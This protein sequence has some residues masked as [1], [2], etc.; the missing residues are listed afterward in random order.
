MKYSFLCFTCYKISPYLSST[1]TV[2]LND[3]SRI[4]FETKGGRFAII[5]SASSCVQD[6][7]EEI[8]ANLHLFM[9]KLIRE[10]SFKTTMNAFLRY[11][12]IL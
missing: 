6:E 7:A 1:F 4:N 12:E 3:I 8:I 5:S 2:V 11:G 9:S 10:I